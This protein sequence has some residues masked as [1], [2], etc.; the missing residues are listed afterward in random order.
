MTGS[1]AHW[2][3]SAFLTIIAAR[4]A[5]YYY[6]VAATRLP[7]RTLLKLGALRFLGGILGGALASGHAFPVLASP[8]R[9]ATASGRIRGVTTSISNSN[10]FKTSNILTLELG[11]GGVEYSPIPGHLMGHS[12]I[13]LPDGGYFAVP[14]G[15]SPYTCLFL[16]ANLTIAGELKA[17][18][19]FGFGGHAVLLPNG[20]QLFGH[21]NRSELL[22]EPSPDNFGEVFVVD[23]E[24]K[25]IIHR[26]TSD[27]IHAHD[28]IISRDK[29]T[30]IVSDD[31]TLGSRNDNAMLSS[32]N[33][34]EFIVAAPA[35]KIY[36]TTSFALIKTVSLPI[37][38][39]L[40]HIEQG[41]DGTV[42]GGV[43]QFV[44][45]NPTGLS[46]LKAAIGK[47]AEN[48]MQ[49]LAGDPAEAAVAFPGPLIR[50]DLNTGG[51]KEHV[52][53]QHQDPFDL[54]CN[55]HSGY[56]L[57][58]F[59]TSNQL[60]RFD[61]ASEQWDYVDTKKY[62]VE[63]PYGVVDLPGTP[64]MAINGFQRGIAIID[65]TTMALVNHFDTETYGLKHMLFDA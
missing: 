19:G 36:D 46:A 10:S 60:S 44:A 4:S 25:K 18:P 13:A 40:V 57:N 52:A 31:G 39:S 58:V 21:F 47:D 41:L 6:M 62:G 1:R 16:N 32:G 50:I 64:L 20:R 3:S 61:P 7:R 11:T 45:N 9:T 27:V 33:P 26:Q 55:A 5:E 63:E 8:A 54:K 42:F 56:L 59:T 14:Y 43:E 17:E 12:M 30:V 38:G 24:T 29:N 15:D 65:V 2:L 48:Y 53:V 23:L 28:M 37:N 49:D 51:V 35:L 22:N 34:F